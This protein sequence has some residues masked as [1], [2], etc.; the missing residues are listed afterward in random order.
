[1]IERIGVTLSKPVIMIIPTRAVV[2]NLIDDHHNVWTIIYN[3][4]QLLNDIGG[5]HRIDVVRKLQI[6]LNSAKVSKDYRALQGFYTPK[7][8]D[9]AIAAL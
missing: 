9:R 7:N 4:D 6:I 5:C 1:M 2:H 8:I 3:L